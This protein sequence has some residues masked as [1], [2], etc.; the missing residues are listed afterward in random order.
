[1]CGIAGYIGKKT[2]GKSAIDTTL[3]LMKNRGPDFQDW[4]SFG[5]N[6]TN[7]YLLHSRLSIIDLVDI[8]SIEQM[9]SS[10]AASNHSSKFLFSFINCKIFL[11]H[12]LK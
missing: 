3:C 7:V 10:K 11:E 5:V 2:I 1:M 9:I 4:R 8:A 6:D 12:Q